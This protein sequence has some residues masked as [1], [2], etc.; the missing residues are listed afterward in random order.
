MQFGTLQMKEEEYV[1]TYF[2]W[3]D[4]IM[5]SIK[6]LRYTIEQDSIVQKI[7]RTL[8]PCFKSKVS[9]LEEKTNLDDVQKDELHG[10]LIVY[11]MGIENENG[12]RKEV[13]Y[14]P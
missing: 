6:G 5:N 1:A 3:V 14:Q 12:S 2:L 4:G 8:P 11:E 9:F 7:M 10:I 13:S